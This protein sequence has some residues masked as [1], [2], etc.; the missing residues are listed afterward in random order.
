[1]D[2]LKESMMGAGDLGDEARA[3]SRV[4]S[5]LKTVEGFSNPVAVAPAFFIG[6]DAAAACLTDHVLP[7]DVELQLKQMLERTE[8][9]PLMVYPGH[10]AGTDGLVERLFCVNRGDASERLGE[11]K[12]VIA[13]MYERLASMEGSSA[14]GLAVARVSGRSHGR[15]FFPDVSGVAMSINP[16]AWSEFI[17]P[18]DGAVRLVCGLGT[19][20]DRP[21]EDYSRLVSLGA[22]DRRPEA[23]FDEIVRQAQRRVDFIDL[24]QNKTGSDY[25]TDLIREAVG[26]SLD[27]LS[28]E[29]EVVSPLTGERNRVLTLDGLVSRTALVKDLV[30]LLDALRPVFDRP[31][32]LH[33]DLVFETVRKW[34]L[35]ISACR[36]ADPGRLAAARAALQGP[37]Q[38][39]RIFEARTAV[40]GRSRVQRVDRLVVV[41]PSV[42]GRMPMQDRFEIA[43]LVGRVNR[44]LPAGNT[45]LIG[46]G[47]WGTTTPSLGVPVSFSEI[48]RMSAIVELAMMHEHLT[49]ELSMATHFLNDLVA[50]DRI[51]AALTPGRPGEWFS[52]EPFDRWPNRLE[53]VVPGAGKWAAAVKVIEAADVAGEG[54]SMGLCADGF[55]PSLICGTGAIRH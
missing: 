15:R 50:A 11:L 37:D 46:P 52:E 30:R 29:D 7:E 12:A 10:A 42:F 8:P 23:G 3:L 4:A 25:F 35:F 55:E 16:Y 38:V 40:I 27:L 18:K 43:R 41:M 32:E 48:D 45:V 49:P 20:F 17:Q 19:R 39:Q 9:G 54:Q 36:V 47:R 34:K 53:R 14:A 6:S 26:L 5:T 51:Y 31:F 24:E 2:E 1:M 28:T 44:A 21:D 13:A 33:F 22:P